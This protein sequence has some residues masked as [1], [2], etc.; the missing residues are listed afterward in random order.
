[1]EGEAGE[2]KTA[3]EAEADVCEEEEVCEEEVVH[4]PPVVS[5]RTKPACVVVYIVV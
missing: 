3:Q 4:T 2:D 1:L 5:D